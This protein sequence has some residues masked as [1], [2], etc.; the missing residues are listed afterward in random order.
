MLRLTCPVCGIEADESW[1]HPG[2]EAGLRRVVAE[3]VEAGGEAL[4][5]YLYMRQSPRGRS[6]ELWL[7]RHGCGKWFEAV[8]DSVTQEIVE[9]SRLGGAAPDPK[10]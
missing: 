2:G 10:S 9:I 4:A 7:C 3:G 6:H 8:R 5:D 1:F